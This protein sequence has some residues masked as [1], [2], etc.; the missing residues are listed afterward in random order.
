MVNKLVHYSAI[1]IASPSR[2]LVRSQ[3]KPT[4]YIDDD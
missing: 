3:R 4:D 2:E 1:L